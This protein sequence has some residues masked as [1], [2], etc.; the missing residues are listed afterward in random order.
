MEQKK[1]RG[2]DFFSVFFYCFSPFQQQQCP[3]YARA[4]DNSIRGKASPSA[5]AAATLF[6][7]P[8]SPRWFRFWVD[9]EKAHAT[10]R[11]GKSATN[12]R[13]GGNLVFFCKKQEGTLFL[14][15]G[16]KK[17]LTFKMRTSGAGAGRGAVVAVT[18]APPAGGLLVMMNIHP[19][20]SLHTTLPL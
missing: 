11:D 14:P 18:S 2:K 20:P 5:A 6:P 15:Q 1:E 17:K 7:L 4:H 8:I 19:P 13:R 12:E 16:G 3:P 10:R 9:G